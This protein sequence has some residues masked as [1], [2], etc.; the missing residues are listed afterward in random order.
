ME[1]N[2]ENHEN[3]ENNE[4]KEEQNNEEQNNE[5]H[6]QINEN[7][8]QINETNGNEKEENISQNNSLEHKENPPETNEESPQEQLENSEEIKNSALEQSTEM[9]NSNNNNSQNAEN[10]PTLNL[11][12]NN[13]NQNTL[14]NLNTDESDNHKKTENKNAYQLSTNITE[15]N[16]NNLILHTSQSEA[17]LKIRDNIRQMCY[18]QVRNQ[19]YREM[20]KLDYTFK[21]KLMDAEQKKVEEVTNERELSEQEKKI[22]REKEIQEIKE[23]LKLTGDEEKKYLELYRCNE[24]EDDMTD[25]KNSYKDHVYKTLEFG[26][27]R[28]VEPKAFKVFFKKMH[29]NEEI[30]RKGGIGIQTPSMN[31]I[32]AT[33][34]FRI[35]PNPIG[36][37]KKKGEDRILD[38]KNK[39]LGDNY[40]RCL[41]ESLAV[42]DH[43][44]DLNLSKNRLSDM[45]IIPLMT[46]IL[47]NTALLKRLVQF[48]LSFNRVGIAATELISQ[49]I[50]NVDCNVEYFNIE[51]NNLGNTNARK[52]IESISGNLG[53]KLRYLNLAQND[54]DDDVSLE[55]STLIKNAEYLNVLILYQNQF[56]NKGAGNIMSELKKHNRIKILDLSWNLIGTNLTDEVPTLDELLKANKNPNNRFDNAYLDELLVTREYRRNNSLSPVKVGSRVSFFTSNL[57]ELFHNKDTELLHLDISYNNINVVDARAISENIKDNHSILGIHVDGNDMY[58]D[59]LGFVYPIEKSKY[60]SNHFANSQ[61]FYRISNDH[62]LIRSGAINIQKLRSKNNCWICEGWREIKFHYKPSKYNGSMD[63][64]FMRLH[65]NFENYKS[66]DLR[67]S[68]D[69]FICHRMCPPGLLNFF[70]TMNGVPVDNYGPITHELKDAIIYTQEKP[71]KEFEDEEDEEEESEKKKFIITKVAQTNVDVNPEVISIPGYIKM[72]KFCVPRPENI[73]NLKKRPKTPWSFPVSIW[74]WYGYDYNGETEDKVNSAFE[75][76]YNRCKFEKDKDL[77]AEDE[78]DLKDTLKKKYP[79]I[80][81]TYKNLS[82]YLGWK[83]WQIG[84]NQI[85]EFAQNCPDLL[86]KNYLINDVLV[87]VTETKSNVTDKQERK[88]NANIPDNII[89]HQ[90]LMLLFKVAK[91]KYFRTKQ[92]TSLPEAVDY[93]FEHNYDAYLNQFDNHKWRKERYYNEEVDNV[94]KAY[95][96]VFDALFYT[97]APQQIMGRKD[98]FWMLLENYTNLC[99]NLMDTDFPVKDIPVLFNLSMRLQVNEIDSDKHYNMDFPEFLEAIC[100]FIDRLSP[101]PPGEDPNK[102]DMQKRQDQPL[103]VKIETMIPKLLKLINGPKKAVKD[104]FTMP[105]R[106]VDTGLLI[107]DYDNPLYEGKLP[108]KPR[109]K[110]KDTTIA[111]VT[112][113]Q[114]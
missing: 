45:S 1:E 41:T 83:I 76:D 16:N 55:L 75:F 42:S 84:Q 81:D 70:L 105:S 113:D 73:L 48:D 24:L 27:T 11:N 17:F 35:V 99:S 60:K 64:A 30:V 50:S 109:R 108:P 97:Y 37:V 26:Q 110:K 3:D 95:I 61:I 29:K 44:T 92:I 58:V 7:H 20:T 102:W 107:I 87:K 100:R 65:L 114:K 94:L 34:K 9:N 93:A 63:K 68:H 69:S 19:R 8:S 82:A 106:D 59:E 5:E 51:G 103:D 47:K 80:L 74:A 111:N 79:K 46:T 56:K 32:R 25:L 31:L 112:S 38:L 101:V 23:S 62:P 90:F 33:K 12:T 40:V 85:T 71:P 104:K 88:T 54:L 14:E 2:D 53:D 39:G 43:I 4:N 49:F 13:N 10:I 52:I 96:P 28:Y 21:K 67:L 66:Y 91:D 18:P 86:D 36:V 15:Q 57:C 6:S 78:I 89:R 72:I 22:Q 77:S 98:S